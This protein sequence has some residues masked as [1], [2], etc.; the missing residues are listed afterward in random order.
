[1]WLPLKPSA[2]IC[3]VAPVMT[4]SKTRATCYWLSPAIFIT[5]DH[6]KCYN[7]AKRNLASSR[8]VSIWTH[9]S[10]ISR[11]TM[12]GDFDF[13]GW[14]L[15]K[16]FL[17]FLTFHYR[18]FSLFLSLF[19]FYFFSF[20]HFM[21]FLTNGS[22]SESLITITFNDGFLSKERRGQIRKSFNHITFSWYAKTHLI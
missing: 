20:L 10:K 19:F 5:I 22:I 11:K 12:E 15:E 3:Q 14:W 13:N 6:L 21:V 2:T 17:F 7:K 9:G 16:S 8:A 1:M 4:A 18:N